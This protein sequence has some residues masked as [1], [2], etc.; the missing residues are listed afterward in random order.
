VWTKPVTI[1]VDGGTGRFAELLADTLRYQKGYKLVGEKTIGDSVYTT[2]VDLADG[3]AYVI[4]T[5][6]LTPISGIDFTKKGFSVDVN[7]AQDKSDDAPLSQAL[8][9]LD[10]E[11]G[12][13]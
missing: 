1:L 2:M 12:G 7:C 11:P 13:I 5:G 8:K 3:S 6:K 9:V 4:T 10:A